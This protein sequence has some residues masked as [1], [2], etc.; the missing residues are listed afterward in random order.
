LRDQPP[1]DSGAYVASAFSHMLPGPPPNLGQTEITTSQPPGR[2]PAV[3][4][5]GVHFY[6]IRRPVT[7]DSIKL[8]GGPLTW[9]T[10]VRIRFAFLGNIQPFRSE[11]ARIFLL[12]TRTANCELHMHRRTDETPMNLIPVWCEILLQIA[13]VSLSFIACILN[14]LAAIGFRGMRERHPLVTGSFT[15]QSAAWKRT[16]TLAQLLLTASPRWAQAITVFVGR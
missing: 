16:R 1:S 3:D 11:S 6:P 2:A 8:G 4:S 10:L 7:N 13:D 5:G 14:S 12:G 9:G 15:G